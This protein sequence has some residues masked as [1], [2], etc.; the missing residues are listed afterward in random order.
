MKTNIGDFTIEYCPWCDN[1]TVIYKIGVTA[2][3]ECGKPL[4]PCSMC[5]RCNY[6]TC[7]YGC[8]GGKE[9]EFKT[10]TNP[11]ITSKEAS[12]LYGLL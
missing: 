7:A 11:K 2:C 8:T 6:E 1:D 10:I 9:D 5:V 4:A 3:P 12:T